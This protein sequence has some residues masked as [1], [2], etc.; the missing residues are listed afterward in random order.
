MD[1]VQTCNTMIKVIYDIIIFKSDWVF[2]III[3]K[4]K[5]ENNFW[6]RR[7]QRGSYAILQFFIFPTLVSQEPSETKRHLQNVHSM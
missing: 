4:E 2:S 7:Q 3:F 5:N 1:A 6:D